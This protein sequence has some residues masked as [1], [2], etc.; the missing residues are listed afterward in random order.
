[1]I[2]TEI[3]YIYGLLDPRTDE[4]RYV[5][6][7][8]NPRTRI[9]KHLSERYNHNSYKDRWI[10]K[11][12]DDG[13]KP[14]LL[15]I[16]VVPKNNWQFWE[17]YYIS[18]FKE[19]GVKLTNGTEGGDQPPSTKGRRHTKESKEKMSRSKKGKPIP[20]LNDGKKRTKK[21]KEN[22]SKSLKGR[23]SPNKGKTFSKEMCLILSNASTLKK[24]VRQLDLE[25]NLIEV[26]DSVNQ[27]QKELKLRH[28]S[29]CCRNI[30]YRTV[31]GFMWE[32]EN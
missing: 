17:M 13:V 11:L 32:Y 22:L 8:I 5:G 20:W 12:M 29:E 25:G 24:R 21:H 3:V 18:Y 27:I 6:K 31:G 2:V 19:L 1:M 30:K 14:K 16:D 28:I 26:W 9:R 10:R 4:L 15:I 7:S 23:K